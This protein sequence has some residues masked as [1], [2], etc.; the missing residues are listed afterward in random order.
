VFVG[1][2]NFLS[3]SVSF[4]LVLASTFLKWLLSEPF[5]CLLGTTVGHCHNYLIV[6]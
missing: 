2:R 5:L 6:S 3:V 4:D 1:R